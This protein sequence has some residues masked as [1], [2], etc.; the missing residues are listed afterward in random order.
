[1]RRQL[2]Q[3]QLY[4]ETRDLSAMK[5]KGQKGRYIHTM[6]EVTELSV[7][8]QELEL[9]AA[10]DT[11]LL[12]LDFKCFLRLCLSRQSLRAEAAMRAG[13]TW[14]CFM[15]LLFAWRR[16]KA[17]GHGPHTMMTEILLC[18]LTEETTL[19]HH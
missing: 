15:G 18:N 5:A 19:I 16:R 1:M 17:R 12:R 3:H 9:A 2:Y 11:S 13:N 10:Q 8:F 14:L 6:E 4:L 7:R